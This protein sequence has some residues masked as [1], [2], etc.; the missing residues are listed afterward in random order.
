MFPQPVMIGGIV[1]GA[2]GILAALEIWYFGLLM[3]F[4]GGYVGLGV[5]GVRI[6]AEGKRYKSYS[7]WLG[8]R[9]G[10]WKSMEPF[11]YVSVL[12]KQIGLTM[13]SRGNRSVDVGESTYVVCLLS[14]THRTKVII[15]QEDTRR[16]AE[17]YAEFIASELNKQV[18]QYAPE[19]SAQTRARNM[20]RR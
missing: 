12:G 14:P 9:S 1:F 20:R 18:V 16:Q 10:K 13:A 5:N 6:D 8:M 15:R 11:P 7:K 19:I 17:K 3:I 2:V 4:L